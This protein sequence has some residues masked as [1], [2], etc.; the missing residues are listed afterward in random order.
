MPESERTASSSRKGA[1]RWRRRAAESRRRSRERR[2]RP[3]RGQVERWK[4]EAGRGSQGA[5]R[6]GR[7]RG[8]LKVV[9]T[10]QPPENQ[11]WGRSSCAQREEPIVDRARRAGVERR[12]VM[13]WRPWVLDVG[14]KSGRKRQRR[15]VAMLIERETARRQWRAQIG[16]ELR[17]RR[18]SSL[19]GLAVEAT[20]GSCWSC[21]GSRGGSKALDARS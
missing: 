19:G 16:S 10:L 4:L 12:W 1:C 5:G 11:D 20:R 13:L 8:G 3:G 18:R 14:Q 9:A 21:L 15:V 7:G 2:F 17:D 6:G